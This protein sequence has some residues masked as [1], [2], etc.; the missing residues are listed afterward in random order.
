MFLVCDSLRS[1][2]QVKI[3]YFRSGYYSLSN[4]YFG[5]IQASDNFVDFIFMDKKSRA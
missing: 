4:L 5:V 3:W 2:I 1:L